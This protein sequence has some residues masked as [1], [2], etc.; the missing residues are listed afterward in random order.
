M[1]RPVSFWLPFGSILRKLRQGGFSGGDGGGEGIHTQ[2]AGAA[3]R[4]ATSDTYYLTTG[5]TR[6]ARVMC[7]W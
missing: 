5:T 6:L 2:R 3:G 7:P 1:G 4:V